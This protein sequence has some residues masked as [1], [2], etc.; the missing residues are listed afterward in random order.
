MVGV[1]VV[2][3]PSKGPMPAPSLSGLLHSWPLMPQQV[4]I[5]PHLHQRLLDTY[6]QVQ[7]SRLW[8]HC[9]FLL[10][11][12]VY[13]VLFVPSKTLF[14]SPVEVLQQNPTGLQCQILGASQ[15]LCQIP[16]LENLLWALELLQQCKNFFDIIF[17]QF[18][19]HLLGGSMVRLMATSSK[20]IFATCINSKVC[21]SQSPCPHGSHC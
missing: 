13:K 16:R 2:I 8:D 5:D 10:T 9:S 14:P 18:V 7:L 19:G 12:V 11:P 4:S 15:S 6:R 1:M 3:T 21:W 17:L 20:K